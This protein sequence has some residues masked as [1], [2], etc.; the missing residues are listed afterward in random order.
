MASRHLLRSFHENTHRHRSKAES[1]ETN[2]S[3]PTADALTPFCDRKVLANPMDRSHQCALRR[4]TKP[5]SRS[6]AL[7]PPPRPLSPSSR[8]H[9]Q[10]A[11]SGPRAHS[12]API[13][14]ES[15]PLRLPLMLLPPPTYSHRNARRSDTAS[16]S[17]LRCRAGQSVRNLPACSKPCRRRGLCAGKSAARNGV[18][19]R[20]LGGMG[21]DRRWSRG[22]LRSRHRAGSDE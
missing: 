8:G 6:F 9:S 20:W 21:S 3:G 18:P 1:K 2:D 12:S 14:E 22:V 17:L 11:L 10:P 4:G 7:N 13:T 16:T 5:I 15:G 19:G